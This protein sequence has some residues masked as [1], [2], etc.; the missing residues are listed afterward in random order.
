M[1]I[2]L[3]MHF[4]SLNGNALIHNALSDKFSQK[5]VIGPQ[6]S[7]REHFFYGTL[8]KNPGSLAP[9]L[10]KMKCWGKASSYKIG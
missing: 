3:K 1:L 4:T 5:W 9:T 7:F 8:A 2:F 10:V 6:I